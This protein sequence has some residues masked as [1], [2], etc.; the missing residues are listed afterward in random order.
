MQ[1]DESLLAIWAIMVNTQTHRQTDTQ[2]DKT[3]VEQ[4]YTISSAS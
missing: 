2:T 4:L 3:S 1:D